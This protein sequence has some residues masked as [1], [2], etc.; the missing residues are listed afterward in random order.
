MGAEKPPSQSTNNTTMMQ[1]KRSAFAVALAVASLFAVMV[2]LDQH[3]SEIKEA[4]FSPTRGFDSMKDPS[5]PYILREHNEDVKARAKAM[6]K[7]YGTSAAGEEA[8]AKADAKEVVTDANDVEKDMD[9]ERKAV[10]KANAEKA[11]SEAEMKSEL[12][13]IFDEQFH[14][15]MVAKRKAAAAKKAKE[16][17]MRKLSKI[18]ADKR[19]KVLE[20]L[21]CNKLKKFYDSAIHE[22]K[23]WW[24]KIQC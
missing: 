23:A 2:V 4:G 18:A 11:A 15:M 17:L 22:D 21:D 16:I 24:D 14:K 8:A 9:K 19:G 20:K 12:R 13:E 3:P 5:A 10:A 1:Y 6:D 7:K